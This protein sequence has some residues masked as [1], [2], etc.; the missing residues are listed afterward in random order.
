MPFHW[1]HKREEKRSLSGMGSRC[2]IVI[3]RGG[4]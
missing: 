1:T 4:R 3:E 2:G